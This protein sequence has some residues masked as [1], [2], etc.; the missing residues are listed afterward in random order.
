MK[1][2]PRPSPINQPYLEGCNRDELRLQQ[3]SGCRK[4]VFYPRVCCPFCGSGTLV[5]ARA[6]GEGEVVS[7]T[8]VHRPQHESFFSETPYYFIAVRLKE[9]P[10]MFSRLLHQGPISESTLVGRGVQAVFVQHTPEQRLPF[11]A[12]SR[13]RV[14][15]KPCP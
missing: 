9:G 5:W 2:V 15:I 8:R 11:F 12:L 10:T 7:F 3:C 4:Y 14:G 1:P 13:A 6:S